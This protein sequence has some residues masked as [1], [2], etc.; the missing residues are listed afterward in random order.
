MQWY[1]RQ[2]REGRE[3]KQV[4]Q[5]WL[6]YLQ[7]QKQ[8]QWQSWGHSWRTIPINQFSGW[9]STCVLIG[10]PKQ[11]LSRE[12]QLYPY[13]H[14]CTHLAQSRFQCSSHTL[15]FAN[16]LRRRF[17]RIGT[18]IVILDFI[19]KL[20]SVRIQSRKLVYRMYFS[21]IKLLFMITR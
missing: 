5:P 3:I 12:F 14:T 1:I 20:T 4:Q 7:Q 8:Y 11:K 10:F 6:L 18:K 17:Y 19:L 2:W 9:P 15:E 21:R 13:V 16:A